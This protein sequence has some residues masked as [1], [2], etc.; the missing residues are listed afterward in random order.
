MDSIYALSSG[1]VPAGV[2]VIRISGPRAGEALE[3][4]IGSLPEPRRAALRNIRAPGRDEVVDQGLVLWFP[5]PKS[6]TG[7]DMAELQVHGGRAV[8]QALFDVL[9][10]LGLRL[11]R[12]GEFLRRAF[13]GGKLDLTEVEGLADLIAAET[14]VQRRQAL[15]QARGGLAGRA[16]AWRLALIDLRAAIEARLDFSDEGDVSEALPPE[17]GKRIAAVRTEMREAL[18]GARSGARLR[19]GFRVAILGRPNAGKS[20]LLNALSRRDVAIVTEE[21]G[22][23]RDVLEVPLDL[24]GYPVLLYDT[25]GLRETASAAETEGVRRARLTAEAADLI[26]WLEDASAPGEGALDVPNRPTWRIATKLDLAPAPAGTELGISVKTGEGLQT[27]LDR[28]SSAAAE[29]LGAGNALVT[30]ERQKEAIGE[31]VAALS[32][33]PASADEITADLLRAASEAIGRLSGRVDVE[34]VLDRLF[35]EFCIGK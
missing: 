1:A 23:T 7:E 3:A 2:A 35:N 34:D 8:V 11:A 16:E 22:T 27:L 20:S 26:L 19:E 31:A 12:P 29:G 6:E 33:A 15:G 21:P 9:A 5:G 18:A 25:A 30:R 24:G 4:L 13:D 10:A 28:L 14:E 17:F 32:A